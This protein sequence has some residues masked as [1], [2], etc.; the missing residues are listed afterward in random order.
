[1]EQNTIETINATLNNLEMLQSNAQ[2]I[3]DLVA[4][5]QAALGA[6]L[7]SLGGKRVCA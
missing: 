4:D 6:L 5:E 7:R 1:M 3:L 2:E